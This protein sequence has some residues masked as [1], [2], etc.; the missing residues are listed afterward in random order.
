MELDTQSYLYNNALIKLSGVGSVRSVNG[1]DSCEP[2][3]FI[4]ILVTPKTGMS[5][6]LPGHRSP[7]IVNTWVN[8]P[9][10]LLYTNRQMWT[11][12]TCP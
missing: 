1:C 3:Y 5:C 4:P 8:I 12:T 6:R 7:H 2:V 10:Y 11:E 9:H